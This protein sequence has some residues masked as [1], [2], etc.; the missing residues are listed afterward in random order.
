MHTSTMEV[1]QYRGDTSNLSM[2]DPRQVVECIKLGLAWHDIIDIG[3]QVSL[4]Q[5]I[6]EELEKLEN[7]GMFFEILIAY[8]H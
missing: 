8:N 1:S 3:K 7:S 2:S 4:I 5:D 6:Y